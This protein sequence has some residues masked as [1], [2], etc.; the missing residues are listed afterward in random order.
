MKK[1]PSTVET[2]AIR[3]RYW[4]GATPKQV[5]LTPRE[6]QV[7]KEIAQG[8]S[9][10]E[11]AAL[12]GVCVRTVENTAGSIMDKTGLRKRTQVCV[13]CWAN[14]LVTVDDINVS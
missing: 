3:D 6:N 4:Y 12:L 1:Q 11:I 8:Y 14:G 10:A 7:A 2:D 13:W 9:N 5:R